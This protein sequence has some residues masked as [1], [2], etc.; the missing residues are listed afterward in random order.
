[1][2]WQFCNICNKVVDEYEDKCY[3]CGSPKEKDDIHQLNKSF[4]NCKKQLNLNFEE[5]K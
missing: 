3:W 2:E 4:G 5:K 1:M